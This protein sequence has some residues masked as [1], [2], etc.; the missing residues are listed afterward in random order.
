MYFAFLHQEEYKEYTLPEWLTYFWIQLSSVW[1]FSL[2]AYCRQDALWCSDV[3]LSVRFLILFPFFCHLWCWNLL[4]LSLVYIAVFISIIIGIWMGF[5]IGLLLIRP[6]TISKRYS[7][8]AWVL[9]CMM[10]EIWFSS[11][12]E[13]ISWWWT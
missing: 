2:Y 13:K 3:C 4:W 9:M 11:V 7:I 12:F 10:Q 1:Y 8:F 6:P 5:I